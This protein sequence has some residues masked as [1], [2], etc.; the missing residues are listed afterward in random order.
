RDLGE[1]IFLGD[2]AELRQVE[3][4]ESGLTLGAAVTLEDGWAALLRHWPSLSE[5]A[6]RFAGPPV[7]HAGT[8][9]GN[10]ANGSPIGDS[11]PV[12]IALGAS[13][14]LRCGSASRDVR[15]QDFYLDYMKNQLQPGEFVESVCVPWQT[16]EAGW[17]VQAHK[18]S[19]RF[20]CDISALSA[21]FALQLDGDRVADVRLAYGGMAG[22]VKR[23]SAAEAALRGQPWNEGPLR[24]AQ[25]ALA[26]DFQ[27]L[28][29]LRA[30]ADY[31]RQ[32][33]AALLERL[34]LSTR[35]AQPVSLA[36]LRVHAA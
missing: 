23:A 26:Q 29:D 20:D 12:L 36:Q 16:G 4:S 25:A 11:A 8:L 24:A 34:W 18:I 19:K 15:L 9:V 7:R 1:V 22:I 3:E 32:T 14:R 28:S 35:L 30:S 6:R 5:M 2:V 31:R 27:P 21:G 13:L 33:A 10:L 17:Q